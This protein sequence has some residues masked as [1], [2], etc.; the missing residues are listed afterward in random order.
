MNKV[1]P[2]RMFS[3]SFAEHSFDIGQIKQEIPPG[4]L[5]SYKIAFRQSY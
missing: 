3:P 4:F 5:R 2:Y 1:I